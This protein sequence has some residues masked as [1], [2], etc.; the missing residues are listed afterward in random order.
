[1]QHYHHRPICNPGQI[2]TQCLHFD[3]YPCP[4]N[5]QPPELRCCRNDAQRSLVC[6]THISDCKHLF[7]WIPPFSTLPMPCVPHHKSQRVSPF[8]IYHI[9]HCLPH[10]PSRT[11]RRAPPSHFCPIP[12]HHSHN[13]PCSRT[14]IT[15][16]CGNPPFPRV[17]SNLVSPSSHSSCFR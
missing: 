6:S 2:T 15:N 5:N 14:L 12:D 17:Q 1:V 8:I 13:N 3:E 16:R 11:S 9:S 7:F 10:T 4:G